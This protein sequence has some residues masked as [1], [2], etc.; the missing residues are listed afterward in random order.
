MNRIAVVGCGQ[1]GSTYVP[2]IRK[3]TDVP[4]I[5]VEHDRSKW[6]KSWQEDLQIVESIDKVS[7]C[8]TAFVLSNTPAHAKN[9]AALVARG[10]RNIF[11]EKPIVMKLEELQKLE[12]VMMA[13]PEVE[14]YTA[15]L[16]NFSGAVNALSEYIDENDLFL[17]SI[18]VEWGKDRCGNNRPTAG[19]LED[20]SVHGLSILHRLA[21]GFGLKAVSL[22]ALTDHTTFVDLGVQS[23]AKALDESFPNHPIATS[24]VQSTWYTERGNFI[25]S[26]RSSYLRPSQKREVNG[27][28]TARDGS[29]HLFSISFDEKDEGGVSDRLMIRKAGPNN[30]AEVYKSFYVNK[31]EAEVKAFLSAADGSIVDGRLTDLDESSFLAEIVDACVKSATADGQVVEIAK[32]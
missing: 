1:M 17:R 24:F 12:S 31:V 20:E 6:G 4:L 30:L 16:M 5:L 19:N 22:S 2:I 15:Y 13:Y 26:L 32:A 29:A 23:A 9:I 28:L 8:D 25:A 10:C 21:Q 27:V 14:I 7:G 18:S 3:L 11:V